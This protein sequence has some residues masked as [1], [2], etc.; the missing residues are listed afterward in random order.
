MTNTSNLLS[1]FRSDLTELMVKPNLRP[2]LCNGSPLACT[3]FI[4]GFNPAT[5]LD[6]SFWDYW[7]DVSGYDKPAMMRDYLKTRGLSKPKGVRARIERIVDQLPQGACLE[8]N[9]CSTPTKKMEH[10]DRSHRTTEIFE[11]LLRRLKP[12]LIYAHSN[13]PIKYFQQF[14][15]K[16]FSSGTPQTV[17]WENQEFLLL[18]TSG[19]LFSMGYPEASIMGQALAELSLI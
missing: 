14:T 9:I 1:K 12:S 3:T 5:S 6:G 17:K 7:N 15:D 2:F 4:V 10:L 19:P 16:D 8:T 13:E 11:F 18:A